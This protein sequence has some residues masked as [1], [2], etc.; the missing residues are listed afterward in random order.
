MRMY[1]TLE[2][3]KRAEE[4]HKLMWKEQVDILV[5]SGWY[6]SADAASKFFVR[7]LH[8]MWAHEIAATGIEIDDETS[9]EKL[10]GLTPT[11]LLLIHLFAYGYSE[12]RRYLKLSGKS[13]S[14]QVWPPFRQ[15]AVVHMFHAIPKRDIA[16]IVGKSQGA[17]EDA[18]SRFRGRGSS[19]L[20]RDLSLVQPIA[21]NTGVM[22][23]VRLSK[24]LSF[25]FMREDYER[26][27]VYASKQSESQI[28]TWETQAIHC[29][30]GLIKTN[31]VPSSTQLIH[32]HDINNQP[33]DTIH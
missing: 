6:K 15:G 2:Q 18:L 25:C 33:V 28:D 7:R 30:R 14:I 3:A 8:E 19:E 12:N 26:G 23:D 5:K 24:Q 22:L 21:I 32:E 27:K 16:K 31:A 4:Q 29:G 1:Q 9:L 17:V 10:L 11:M 13:P 20:I